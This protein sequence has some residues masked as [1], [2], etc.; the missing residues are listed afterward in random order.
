MEG[1][2]GYCDNIEKSMCLCRYKIILTVASG[3]KVSVIDQRLTAVLLFNPWNSRK[4]FPTH[5]H[6]TSSAPSL[7]RG[8]LL[9][10]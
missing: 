6:Q 9:L 4:S 7:L 5:T 10:P 2:R 3:E 1:G 8:H